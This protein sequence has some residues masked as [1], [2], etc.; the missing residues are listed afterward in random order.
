VQEVELDL[1]AHAADALLQLLL[2]CGNLEEY[3]RREGR[4][5]ERS[6]SSF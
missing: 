3:E 1:E 6:A 4:T 2:H 5:E